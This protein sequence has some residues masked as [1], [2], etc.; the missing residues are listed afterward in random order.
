MLVH[1]LDI[2]NTTIHWAT[3]ESGDTLH[4]PVFNQGSLLT[5]EA[6][7]WLA[8]PPFSHPDK[9]VVSSVVPQLD[10]MIDRLGWT[11]L[12]DSDIPLSI[13]V[14][15]PQTVGADRLVNALGAYAQWGGPT[16]VIDSGTATTCCLID[17]DGA[18]SGGVI[19]P[20]M[21]SSAKALAQHTAKLPHITLQVIPDWIGVTT[22]SAMAIGVVRSHLL[23]LSGFIQYYRNKWPRLTVIGTGGGLSTIHSQLDLDG[24]DPYLWIKGIKVILN[25]ALSLY[26]LPPVE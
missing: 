11:R 22:E 2:G 7:N 15:F 4:S 26:S 1:L 21:A 18:Y 6:P 9:V 25:P 5:E 20:G 10:P 12:T 13:R 19:F 8:T 16:V 23:A 17:G 24:Y 14:P 3:I